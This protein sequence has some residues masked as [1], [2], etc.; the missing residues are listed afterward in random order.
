MAYFA[1]ALT[2]LA[3]TP[4]QI[5]V[6]SGLSGS[7]NFSAADAEQYSQQLPAYLQDDVGGEVSL[8]RSAKTV[9]KS[10]VLLYQKDY[11]AFA[12]PAAYQGNARLYNFYLASRWLNSVFP[13]FYRSNDCPNCLLDKDDWRINMSAAFL[14]SSDLAANQDL[15]N[16]WAKIYKLQSFFSGLRGDLSYLNY[17]QVFD[18]SFSGKTDITQVLQGAPADNDANLTVLQNKLAAINFSALEGGLSKTATS[19][20]PILGFKMLTG[21][22]WPDNYIFS[23]LDYPVVG[24]FLGNAAVGS[25][26]PT[27]CNPDNKHDLYKCVGSAY[28]ILN[29]I[30]PLS[31]STNKYFADNSD[32]GGY[33]VQAKN[34]RGM[35]A[36]FNINSWHANSYWVNFDVSSK[37]LRAPE[38]SK[39]GIMQSSAWQARNF[40]TVLAAWTNEELPSDT[41]SSYAS[42]DS[43][44]LNQTGAQSL[45]PL[46]GYV[47]PDLTLIKDL[48]ANTEMITKMLTL[49]NV[50]DGENSVVADLKTMDKNLTGAQTIAEKELQGQDLSLEDNTFITDLTHAFSVSSEGNKSFVI[51][52]ESG[53]KMTEK[54]AGVSL[55]V[56]SFQRGD[57]KYFAVGPV[58]NWQETNRQ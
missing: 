29:L 27:A 4:N 3:P 10:P 54:L 18:D 37:F 46:Y 6:V 30:Y 55:E 17:K 28:D 22:Y 34:L 13:L 47:E 21:D 1:T 35:F 51:I 24:K 5:S 33:V 36:N 16:S 12:V 32:Y 42:Q 2:L 57:E 41:F 14:I 56:Y 26:T 43:S 39:V 20:K 15:Q 48:V 38:I 9:A 31:T 11:S 23:Q 25:K 8:I 52:P 58:F 49:L 40:N 53:Q 44:R 7:T 45:T 50:G 19:T